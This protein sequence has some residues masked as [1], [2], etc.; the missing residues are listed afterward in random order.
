MSS[1]GD[2]IM[3]VS[4]YVE[5]F[6]KD[7]AYTIQLKK[8]ITDYLFKKYNIGDIFIRFKTDIFFE[9]VNLYSNKC[10]TLKIEGE[11]KIGDDDEYMDCV[12]ELTYVSIMFELL[13]IITKKKL[14]E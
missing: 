5:K 14:R 12:N 11:Y 2:E 10:H 4:D 13:N 9:S 6:C 1:Y 7:N 3:T 8:D